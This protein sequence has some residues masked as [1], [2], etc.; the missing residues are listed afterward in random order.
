MTSPSLQRVP[1]SQR[2]KSRRRRLVKRYGKLSVRRLADFMGRQ[3]LVGDAPV[4]DTALFPFVRLLEENWRT[5]RA[6]LERVLKDRAELPAFHDISP[7]QMKISRGKGWKTFIL[8]GF[9]HR[10]ERNCARCPETARLLSQ[11]P[12]LQTAFFSILEPRYH[13]P[14]HRGVTKGILRCHLGLVVPKQ[15]ENCTMRVGGQTYAWEEG[16]CL[17]FDD[18]YKHEVTNATD[19]DRVVLL[20]DFDRPMRPVG[21][22]VSRAVIW[23]IKRSA[24][25]RDAEQNQKDWEARIEAAVRKADTMLDDRTL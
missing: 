11:V 13:I 15:R 9:G 22:L 6:D 4:L 25:Y 5:I 16:K 8:Y 2:F 23:A 10:S 24:F 20:F 3:S 12:G 1:L 17:V 21:R 19:E 7:D 14:E 18:T